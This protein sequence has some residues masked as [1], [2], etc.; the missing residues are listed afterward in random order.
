M[1]IFI[2]CNLGYVYGNQ[3]SGFEVSS[4]NAYIPEGES[5]LDCRCCA[6]SLA[7]S[8]FVLPYVQNLSYHSSLLEYYI[9]VLIRISLFLPSTTSSGTYRLPLMSLRTI[10]PSLT[11]TLNPAAQCMGLM[12][13]EGCGITQA[14][15]LLVSLEASPF[16][17]F[18]V[19]S[20]HSADQLHSHCLSTLI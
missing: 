13:S 14:S 5:F 8:R 6:S 16:P 4:C 20:R 18:R 9:R 2:A 10:A 11:M 3:T 7:L 12:H 15:Y 1:L 17:I 19:Q